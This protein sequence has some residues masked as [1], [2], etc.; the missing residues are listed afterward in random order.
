MEVH[1]FAYGCPI[2]VASF[3][4]KTILFPLNC[5]CNFVENQLTIY[6]WVYFLGCLPIDRYVNPFAN[7]SLS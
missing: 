7:T 4:Q 6:E 3:V 2:V 1:S 5:L